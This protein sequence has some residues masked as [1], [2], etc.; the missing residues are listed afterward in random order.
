MR[1]SP[2]FH[3]CRL[4]VG[5]AP[6]GSTCCVMTRLTLGDPGRFVYNVSP[7]MEYH[8]G[9]EDELMRAAGSDGTDLFDQDISLDSVIVDLRD[10]SLRAETFIKDYSYLIHTGTKIVKPYTPVSDSLLLEF[11]EPVLPNNKYIYFLIKIYP[12]GL[13][14]PELDHLQIG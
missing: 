6:S 3:S 12:A 9:G 10:D 13:F 5:S 14:T 4:Y 8:P 1:T 2:R 11:K 7:Y